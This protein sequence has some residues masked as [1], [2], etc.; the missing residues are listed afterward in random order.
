MN[1]LWKMKQKCS[2]HALNNYTL[3]PALFLFSGVATT[4]KELELLDSDRRN[5]NKF[6]AL[7]I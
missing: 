3:F 6:R 7:N 1:Y 2:Q 5:L 4:A